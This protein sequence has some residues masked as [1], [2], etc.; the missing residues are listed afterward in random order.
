MI[1]VQ[2][3]SD[4]TPQ[5]A[6]TNAITDLLSGRFYI[7][8]RLNLTTFQPISRRNSKIRGRELTM[9]SGIPNANILELSL[10]EER[11]RQQLKEHSEGNNYD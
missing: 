1:R 3:T 11:F 2:T 6:F 5:E 7:T 9:G 4:Y 10:L 8:F